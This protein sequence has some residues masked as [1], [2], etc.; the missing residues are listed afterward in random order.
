MI[1]FGTSFLLIPI[2]EK[3]IEVKV[4]VSKEKLKERAEK[5]AKQEA[6]AKI[7]KHGAAAGG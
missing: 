4:P 6:I 3:I 5:K 1:P 7:R 2:P